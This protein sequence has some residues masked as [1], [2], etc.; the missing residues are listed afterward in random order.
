M[1]NSLKKYVHLDYIELDLINVTLEPI[2][3]SKVFGFSDWIK[4]VFLF[5]LLVIYYIKTIVFQQSFHANSKYKNVL[6]FLFEYWSIFIFIGFIIYRLVYLLCIQV[7]N[8]TSIEV[9]I[10]YMILL[11]L[12][13]MFL[14]FLKL[15][16]NFFSNWIYFSKNKKIK[17]I[18]IY[19]GEILTKYRIITE[20]TASLL[21][22]NPSDLTEEY[23]KQQK[24][25]I[26]TRG[27]FFYMNVF[28]FFCYNTPVQEHAIFLFCMIGVPLYFYFYFNE[29][30]KLEKIKIKILQ[31]KVKKDLPTFLTYKTEIATSCYYA[32]A[33]WGP[34]FLKRAEQVRLFGTEGVVGATFEA[35]VN[36]VKRV[37]DGVKNGLR[38]ASGVVTGYAGYKLFRSENGRIPFADQQYS[39][40]FNN[41]THPEYSVVDHFNELKNSGRY[42]EAYLNSLINPDGTLNKVKIECIYHEDLVKHVN[43]DTLKNI[44][45][46]QID[47]DSTEGVKEGKAE[48]EIT[49]NL[50][51]ESDSAYRKKLLDEAEYEV[52]QSRKKGVVNIRQEVL[53]QQRR[54]EY[55]LSLLKDLKIAPE[56]KLY[57]KDVIIGNK[58][59]P[60]Q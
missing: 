13:S 36:G 30:D 51:N 53:V 6:V 58:V 16:P 27:Y 12:L 48:P 49:Q 26:E 3:I 14:V 19:L 29:C 23:N 22:V 46:H 42:T 24:K 50:K 32:K 34:Q 8:N 1:V 57:L 33:T 55:N 39:R 18:I 20:T 44:K 59:P 52:Q 11:I 21:F 5:F 45:N 35:I 17:S 47:Q 37:P 10:L 56:T 4:V 7:K 28:L 54:D 2:F 31:E 38:W 41:Y 9:I 25:V 40:I 43:Q 60:S 15:N